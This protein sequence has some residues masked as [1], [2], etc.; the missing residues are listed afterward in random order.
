MAEKKKSTTAPAAKKT[1][2]KSSTKSATTKSAATKPAPKKT[3][4]TVSVNENLRRATSLTNKIVYMLVNDNITK[5]QMMWKY[6]V[7]IEEDEKVYVVGW[8]NNIS[9]KLGNY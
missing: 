6:G 3:L 7:V 9:T 4:D 1:A 2:T 8:R 5:I